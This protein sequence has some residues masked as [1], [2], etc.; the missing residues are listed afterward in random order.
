MH[1]PLTLFSALTV[2]N[3]SVAPQ[4]VE[5]ESP[6][7]ALRLALSAAPPRSLPS[8]LAFFFSMFSPPKSSLIG[9]GGR[10]PFYYPRPGTRVRKTRQH[11]LN[12]RQATGLGEEFKVY[13]HQC[14]LL[15]T[16]RKEQSF[17]KR[18]ILL[19]RN[20]SSPGPYG[21][22]PPVLLIKNSLASA[23]GPGEDN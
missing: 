4:V 9:F 11:L 3:S 16:H 17:E 20:T 6:T 2:F 14:P 13:F 15:L 19:L 12:F 7:T 23:G 8:S 1:P 22:L 21:R 10:C 5:L 18:H